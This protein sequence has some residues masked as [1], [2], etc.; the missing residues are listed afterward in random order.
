MI[1]LNVLVHLYIFK[2]ISSIKFPI[3]NLLIYKFYDYSH[4]C[5]IILKNEL[6]YFEGYKCR[7][8]NEKK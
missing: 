8:G 3:N 2:Y 5:Q 4:F 6:K 7:H 1:L